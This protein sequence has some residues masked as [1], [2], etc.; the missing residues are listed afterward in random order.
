MKAIRR[1]YGS[2]AECSDEERP[3]DKR[4]ER[5][6]AESGLLLPPPFVIPLYV[7]A[8]YLHEQ[9]LEAFCYDL[10]YATYAGVYAD[11]SY[12]S[13]CWRRFATT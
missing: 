2:K 7:C 8:Y 6:V 5:E 4:R 11:V 10:S 9:V 12:M 1:L 13:R 3:G